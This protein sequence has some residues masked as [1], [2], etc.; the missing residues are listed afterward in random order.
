MSEDGVAGL[1]SDLEDPSQPPSQSQAESC[2]MFEDGFE[3]ADLF[4]SNGPSQ[5]MQ[6][7]SDFEFLS[8]DEMSSLQY[9]EIK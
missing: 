9:R 6:P 5:Q 7:S 8:E 2:D 1:F 4:S 3:V